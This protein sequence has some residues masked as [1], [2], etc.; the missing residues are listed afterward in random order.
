MVVAGA[1]AT[2]SFPEN[3]AIADSPARITKGLTEDDTPTAFLEQQQAKINQIDEELVRLL[4]QRMN[5]VTGITAIKEKVGYVV[6]DPEREQQASETTLN[7]VED[8]K[9]EEVLSETFQGI[10]DVSK[11]FQEK[12]LG[13]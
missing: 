5:A 1:A 3:C 8:V 6:L 13:G 9:Y 7:H 2:K 11:R 12:H 4:E 10:M